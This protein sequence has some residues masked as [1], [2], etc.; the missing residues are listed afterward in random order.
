M[1]TA[2]INRK[3]AETDI[4]LKLSL[5]VCEKSDIIIMRLKRVAIG[6]VVLS[7]LESGKWRALSEEE[8]E[9]LKNS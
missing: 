8:V 5:D 2:S 1:R 4:A 7:D 3:T 9:Y 6:D